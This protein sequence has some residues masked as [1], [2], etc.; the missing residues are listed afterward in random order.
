MFLIQGSYPLLFFLGSV[1]FVMGAFLSSGVLHPIAM[2]SLN[3]QLESWRI[4]VR[5]GLMAPII[6]AERASKQFTERKMGGVVGLPVD[7]GTASPVGK[8]DFRRT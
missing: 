3:D 1:G 7:D 5:F 6:L 4:L 8:R 2:V